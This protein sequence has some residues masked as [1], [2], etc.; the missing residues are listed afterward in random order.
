M[1]HAHAEILR[2]YGP[3]PGADRVGGVTFDGEN[4][5]FA[6]G[7]KLNAVDPFGYLRSTLTA[8]VNGYKQSQIAHL[9]PWNYRLG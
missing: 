7:D 9:L 3:F 1:K 4:V 8:L 6:S 2:E 5:W